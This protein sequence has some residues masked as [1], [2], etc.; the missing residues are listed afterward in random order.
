MKVWTLFINGFLEVFSMSTDRSALFV[1]A[2]ARA[3][4]DNRKGVFVDWK[5][6]VSGEG[7]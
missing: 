4:P 5:T 1:P 2:L 3:W 6:R 7:R